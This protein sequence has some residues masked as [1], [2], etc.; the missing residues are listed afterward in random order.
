MLL[1]H[2][3]AETT[4]DERAFFFSI[5]S[6]CPANLLSLSAALHSCSLATAH[7]SLT[8]DAALAH[9]VAQFTR[10]NMPLLGED[11]PILSGS[12]RG[13]RR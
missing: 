5:I 2:L 3:E 6:L 4:G 13:W 12:L 9:W 10:A 7:E 1:A 11:A 8:F